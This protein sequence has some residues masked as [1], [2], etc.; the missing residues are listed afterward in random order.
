M[1]KRL[2]DNVAMKLIDARL[3]IYGGIITNDVY[4]HLGLGRQKVSALF[5][6]YMELNPGAMVYDTVKRKY[7]VTDLFKPSILCEE[8]D[9]ENWIADLDK[10]KEVEN[11]ALEFINALIT[12]FG[13]Y[14]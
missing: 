13:F 1:S 6:S 8:W 9:L 2:L 5:R 4:W 14:E 11:C 12:V 3:V 7:V 10:K